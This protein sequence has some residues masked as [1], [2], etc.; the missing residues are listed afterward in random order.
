M[1]APICGRSSSAILMAALVV[2]LGAFAFAS[3]ADAHS[4]GCHSAHSC[5]SDHHTYIWYDSAGQGWDCAA[6]GAPEYDPSRDTT[7]INYAGLT[8]Y[9]RAAAPPPADSDGDGVPDGSDAC[10]SV[11]AATTNGCPA[12][13]PA[14]VDTD[15]DGLADAIDSCPTVA[16]S[17]ENGCPAPTKVYIGAI[18]QEIPWTDRLQRPR[19]LVPCSA[20][21]GC[22]VIRLRW[23]N[24]GE[25]TA[26]A[27]G[28]AN[29]NDCRPYCARGHFRKT[30]GARV[31]AYQRREGSC[32]GVTVRY[33]TRVRITWPRRL[34]LARRTMKL[35]RSCE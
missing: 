8:Y 25:P 30:P 16:A 31:L 22:Q 6:P 9:C 1:E 4:D 13:P 12:P 14:P 23:R 35:S 7:T 28:V 2:G 19:R 34:H 18:G 29:I 15:S 17:T 27:R 3:S 26:S 24:W 32:R 21:G 20:D 33:Y 5:P 11:P 10:P